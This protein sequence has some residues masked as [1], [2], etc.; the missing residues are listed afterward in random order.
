MTGHV[1]G[2][3]RPGPALGL[4]KMG[5]PGTS[6]ELSVERPRGLEFAWLGMAGWL[7]IL[8][9]LA[10]SLAGPAIIK[11][12]GRELGFSSHSTSTSGRS[13]TRVALLCF[14]VPGEG[15]ND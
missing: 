13:T 6:V 1:L 7:P 8:E 5:N 14:S 12:P 10:E 3:A 15:C 2:R 9:K 11:C 4:L